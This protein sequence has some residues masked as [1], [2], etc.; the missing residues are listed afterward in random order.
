MASLASAP[1]STDLDAAPVTRLTWAHAA[2]VSLPTFTAASSSGVAHEPWIR[3][4]MLPRITPVIRA[5]C[6]ALVV[7]VV[8]GVATAYV[9][10]IVGSPVWSHSL[11]PWAAISTGVGFVLRGRWRVAALA[12]LVTQLGLVLAFCLSQHAFSGSP[13]STQTVATYV[14]LAL[15]AGPFCGAAA[16]LLRHPCV[17]T[18]TAGLGIVSAPWVVDGVRMMA[19]TLGQDP[20]VGARLVVGAGLL[21]LGIILPLAINGSPRDSLR[22][23]GVAAGVGVFILVAL[24]LHPGGGT[25]DT[26][27]A[28]RTPGLGLSPALP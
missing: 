6:L 3:D 7:G 14:V 10:R 17:V 16:G 19:S 8:G 23:L 5:A 15:V 4:P 13:L 25:Q 27:P 22:N 18:R 26:P 21:T 2:P 9:E 24:V 11:A 12:G 20:L 28:L 1:P